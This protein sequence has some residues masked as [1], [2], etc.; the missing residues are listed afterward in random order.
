MQNTRGEQHVTYAKT[1][2]K[3]GLLAVALGLSACATPLDATFTASDVTDFDGNIATLSALPAAASLPTAGNATYEGLV[4]A[5]IDNDGTLIGNIEL[6][7]DFAAADASAINGRMYNAN[8]L[9]NS[10]IDDQA[11]EGEIDMAGGIDRSD[12]SMDATGSGTFTAV[13]EGFKVDIDVTT[14]V[15][16]TFQTETNNADTITGT[17]DVV[18][19]IKIPFVDDEEFDASGADF[20]AQQQ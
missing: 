17:V 20:Y 19:T 4:G 8:I 10:M 13:A 14:T 5:S 2:T 11:L 16:G 9:N 3:L 18:G 12:N 7:A 15:N 1:G 6:I